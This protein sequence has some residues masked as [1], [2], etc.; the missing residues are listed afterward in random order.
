MDPRR[1]KIHGALKSVAAGMV[2]N[3]KNMEI[4]RSKKRRNV[5]VAWLRLTEILHHRQVVVEMVVMVEIMDGTP[6]PL[7]TIRSETA[8]V[9]GLTIDANREMLTDRNVDQRRK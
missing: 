7:L 4:V 3:M 6:L 1:D 5:N 2:E 9:G 8:Y